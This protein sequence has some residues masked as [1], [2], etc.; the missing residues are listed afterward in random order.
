MRVEEAIESIASSETI[1]GITAAMVM[2]DR[3]NLKAFVNMIHD[4]F[5]RD[6]NGASMIDIYGKEEIETII[7]YGVENNLIIKKN[8]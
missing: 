4:Q 2:R 6:G 1:T 8:D 5:Y 7:N 3:K